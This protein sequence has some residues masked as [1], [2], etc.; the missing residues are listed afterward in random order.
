MSIEPRPAGSVI[1]LDA[2][3]LI[4]FLTGGPAAPQVRSILR[5]GDTGVTAPNLVE[6]LDVSARI[7]ALPIDRAIEILEPL[8]GEVLTIVPLDLPE[9]QRAAEIRAEHYH[10][11][12]RP[13]SLADAVLIAVAGSGDHVATADPDV[14]AVAQAERIG[15][16][17]LPEQG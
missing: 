11:S 17:P 9:A 16:I 4:A 10:R 13:I 6:V 3:A 12:S 2:Y 1:L 7:R 15:T 8:F 5:D 14:I